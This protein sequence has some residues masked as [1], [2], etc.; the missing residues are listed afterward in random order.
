MS[1]LVADIRR[2]L[3]AAVPALAVML[4][5]AQ[6]AVPAPAEGGAPADRPTVALAAR[7]A[8][9]AR[10]VAAAWGA[11][12]PAIGDD[13]ETDDWDWVDRAPESE[14][15]RELSLARAVAWSAFV[16]GLGERYAGHPVRARFFHVVE[17]AI[18]S[19]FAYYRIQGDVRQNKQI[20]YAQLNA[21]AAIEQDGDYYEHI[22]YWLSIDEWY[23]IVRR[24]AR[25]RYP[26][27]PAAQEAFFEA[28]KRYDLGQG[29]QWP[30]DAT[31]THYRQLRSVAER[32]YRNSRL[33]AGAAIFN[34]LAS[35]VDAMALARSHNHAVRE[36]QARLELRVQPRDTV[37]G[38]VV[39]PVLT[40]RY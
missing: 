10:S 22:G 36:E 13:W 14:P 31:R 24:D 4:A 5:S 30:D 25:Y 27:D 18:W 38:L 6:A 20:E 8:L 7:D 26:D 34:R 29:W 12:A 21:G 37:D 3:A 19:T 11:G 16:P 35:M 23:D 9:A 40:K 32:S 1:A 33:A 2:A 17:A 28:N 15:A 39:G